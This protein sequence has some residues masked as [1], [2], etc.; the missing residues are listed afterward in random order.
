MKEDEFVSAV[1]QSMG[2][3]SHEQAERAAARPFRWKFT[4]N[5]LRDLLTRIDRHEQQEAAS[6]IQLEA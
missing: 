6:S 2:V 1:R 3:S 5:D 4:Q